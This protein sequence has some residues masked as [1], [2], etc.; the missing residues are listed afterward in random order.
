M[1]GVCVTRREGRP[2]RKTEQTR[3]NRM[4]PQSRTKQSTKNT[5][6][7]FAGSRPPTRLWGLVLNVIFY[8]ECNHVDRGTILQNKPR[9][10]HTFLCLNVWIVGNTEHYRM[11]YFT[12]VTRVRSWYIGNEQCR[13]CT[14]LQNDCRCVAINIVIV[15]ATYKVHGTQWKY[16]NQISEAARKAWPASLY[17]RAAGRARKRY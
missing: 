16:G 4:S 1:T 12:S 15:R 5:L 2:E 17:P 6:P 11:G 8:F 9:T 13:L 7:R 10:V 3:V 14:E